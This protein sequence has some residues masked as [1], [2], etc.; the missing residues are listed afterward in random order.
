[1]RESLRDLPG[2]IDR[3]FSE[4][5][6]RRELRPNL[7]GLRFTRLL[8][9][10][11]AIGEGF[12][13]DQLL[14]RASA[15]TY[16][17]LLSLIPLVAIVLSLLEAVGIQENLGRLLVRLIAAGSP[18]TVGPILEVIEQVNFAGLGTLGAA[19]LFVTTVLFIGN[20]EQAFNG[21]WGIREARPWMRR[22]P[23]YLAVLLFGPL[24]LGVAVSLGTSLQ[25]QAVVQWIR[26]QPGLSAL[27]GLGLRF[28][29]TLLYAVGLALL[30]WFLPNTQVRVSS[31]VLG[32]LVA[33]V[34]LTLAQ[35]A[36]VGLNM[37]VARYNAIFGGLAIFP[38]LAV[39]IY[40]SCAIFLLGAEVA[41]AH[42]NLGLYRREI[43]GRPLDAAGRELVGLRLAL[44]VARAFREGEAAGNA[45]ELAEELEVP[46]RAVRG[47]IADL[48]EARIIAPSAGDK[49]E[50]GYRLA[51]PA[52]RIEVVDVIHA[53]RGEARLP[54]PE[55]PLSSVVW[56]VLAALEEGAASAA[57]KRTLAELLERV[58]P[59]APPR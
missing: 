26:E 54:A 24:L 55:G 1:M 7:L 31:A 13:R 2:R 15:L 30:Y 4:E 27:Y 21:I 53:V 57:G 35:N 52:D 47:V 28:V 3:F 14:L 12:M 9:L 58:P 51:R 48:Q 32:G 36:Y 46:V 40:F 5:I 19:A 49:S 22:V 59:A 11:A 38:L 42:Q 50:G 56:D 41:F 8:Q 6:W 34:L 45:D 39:W 37:G 17:S 10:V 33:G 29:P 18:E 20:V 23:D 25:S 16:I 44:E 43:R